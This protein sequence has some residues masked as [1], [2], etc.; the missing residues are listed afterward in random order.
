MQPWRAA[1]E[2]EQV[3]GRAASIH[4]RFAPP[5]TNAYTGLIGA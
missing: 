3:K 4:G 1:V 2:G 5:L